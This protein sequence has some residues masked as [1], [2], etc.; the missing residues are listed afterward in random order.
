MA[1]HQ[2]ARFTGIATTVRTTL[3]WQ[4]LAVDLHPK[5]TH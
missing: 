2:T 1:R 3:P 4:F 5:L